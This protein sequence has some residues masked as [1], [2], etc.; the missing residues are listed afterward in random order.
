LWHS[1]SARARASTV[2]K[3]NPFRGRSPHAHTRNARTHYNLRTH[4]LA[5]PHE[6]SPTHFSRATHTHSPHALSLP[7]PH[8]AQTHISTFLTSAFSPLF[9]TSLPRRL[10]LQA[11]F[12]PTHK[13]LSP[14]SQCTTLLLR[15]I[16]AFLTSYTNPFWALLYPPFC[17]SHTDHDALF[18]QHPHLGPATQGSLPFAPKILGALI[19]ALFSTQAKN[20]FPHSS[21]G[22]FK[23]G[24]QTPGKGGLNLS[25][26]ALPFSFGG[27][28]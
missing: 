4:T 5:L 12:L 8:K 27:F 9:Q 14:A 22:R 15:Q 7:S 2:P 18:D 23:P 24:A 19:L 28:P 13:H 1:Q 20:T 17:V 3:S 26:T 11:P 6:F 10:V 25:L 16:T 21:A